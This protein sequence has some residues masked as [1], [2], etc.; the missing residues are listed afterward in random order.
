MLTGRLAHGH[1][2]ERKREEERGREERES[3]RSQDLHY[4][5]IFACSPM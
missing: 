3:D 5:A 1:E 4:F 2:R